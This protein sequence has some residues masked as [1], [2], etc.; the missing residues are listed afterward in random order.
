M[1]GDT[2]G[3]VHHLPISAIPGGLSK[4]GFLLEAIKL[5][6]K[7]LDSACQE[8]VLGAKICP[9]LE[10]CLVDGFFQPTETAVFMKLLWFS[11]NFRC[12]KK[13]K[14]EKQKKGK[15]RV[16]ATSK[17]AD[18]VLHNETTVFGFA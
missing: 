15:E 7:A 10:T 3:S 8:L 14:E 2:P 16:L 13:I 1:T 6:H 4:E 9:V 17:L 12:G 5:H 11:S 18:G